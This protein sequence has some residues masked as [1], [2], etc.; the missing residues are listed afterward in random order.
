MVISVKEPFEDFV[1]NLLGTG[2]S[3]VAAV[4]GEDGHSFVIEEQDV[5]GAR[6]ITLKG[7]AMPYQGVNWGG[8]QRSKLTYYPGNPVASQQLLGPTE[9]DTVIEGTWKDR[10]MS[11]A[12]EIGTAQESG[13]GSGGGALGS[14]KN[15][16]KSA[17]L[18]AL[19]IE[20]SQEIIL[21][22]EVVQIFHSIRRAGTSVRVQYM[23]EVRFGII[24]EF[25]ARYL[26][27]QDI[28]WSM[29]FE[30]RSWDDDAPLRSASEPQDSQNLLDKLNAVLDI[31]SNAPFAVQQL[32]ASL[33]NQINQIADLAQVAFDVL[34]TVDALTDLPGTVLG[35]MIQAVNDLNNELKDLIRRIS[36][37]RWPVTNSAQ[38]LSGPVIDPVTNSR[39]RSAPSKQVLEF[40]RWRRAL[41]LA[42]TDLRRTAS[43]ASDQRI[44]QRIPKTTRIVEVREGATLYDLSQ[45]FY[46]SPDFANYLAAANGLTSVSV[47]GGFQ[48]RVPPRS[49]GPI[50]VD[51][52]KGRAKDCTPCCPDGT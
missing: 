48:L 17:A 1:D 8:E 49:T 5:P 50:S 15:A 33:T 30:W 45:R 6:T 27:P 3:Q 37:V 43:D 21:A 44:R 46:G 13:G 9:E 39:G 23:G 51:L 28:E 12:I 7:R 42:A 40:E 14:I 29:T 19:K 26:R 38:S 36:D 16:A 4:S 18:S 34:R 11:G 32:T 10:F 2:D 47:S 22:E 35:A 41:T 24:K 31:V 20:E 25:T 52:S